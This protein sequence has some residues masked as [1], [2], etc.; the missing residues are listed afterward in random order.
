MENE[1]GRTRKGEREREKERGGKREGERERACSTLQYSAAI[2][3]RFWKY[4]VKGKG[5]G[6][7]IL[8]TGVLHVY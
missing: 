8:G 2:D 6:H 4:I 5:L 7:A 1:K 3:L